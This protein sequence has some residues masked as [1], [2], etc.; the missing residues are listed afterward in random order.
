MDE[1]HPSA[2][3][4]GHR[5]TRIGIL[6]AMYEE[7]DA[8]LADVEQTNTELVIGRTFHR[9]ILHGHEV[10]AVVAGIG[11]TAVATT[12]T[13]L[14]QHFGADF[15][16]LTG[17]AGRVREDLAVGDVIVAS[18]LVHHDLDA[19][20]IF[21]RYHVPTLGRAELETDAA[22]SSLAMAA[23]ESFIAADPG[24]EARVELGLV[25]SGDQFMGRV[26]L[27]D[28]RRRFPDGLAVEMEGAAVAQVCIEAQIPLAV[29][30]SISDDGDA[31]S[32]ER[33]LQSEC[34]RYARAI[35]GGLL[36]AMG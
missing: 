22:I 24:N 26:A 10:I 11:K 12:T 9:G 32:F 31:G 18:H 20:P 7:L 15:I 30:R 35:V 34:G 16:L 36:V 14:I 23:A 25:L 8:V 3:R 5:L 21:P 27:A 2:R 17:A 28:L 29:V 4:P 19:S 33:F 1:T 13:L 6:A